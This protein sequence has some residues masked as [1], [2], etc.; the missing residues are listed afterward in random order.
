MV[1]GSS[2]C[3][4]ILD[5]MEEAD[6]VNCQYAQTAMYVQALWDANRFAITCYSLLN[7]MQFVLLSVT[8]ILYPFSWFM[9][10][11]N[12]GYS[13][14]MLLLEVRQF[15]LHGREYLNDSYNFLDVLSNSFII[16]TAF[17]IYVEGPSMYH[18]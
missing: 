6:H 2:L 15:K 7:I 13:T 14:F 16:T 8:V 11:L 3:I 12:A 1:L 9:M 4:E 5:E 18:S 17:R 10:T